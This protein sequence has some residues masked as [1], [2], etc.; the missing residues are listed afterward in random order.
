LSEQAEGALKK[1]HF[2]GSE[3]YAKLY[4]E[5]FKLS[6]TIDPTVSGQEIR[7]SVGVAT[8]D[9]HRNRLLLV[10]LSC[11][12][13]L[14]QFEGKLPYGS[15]IMCVIDKSRPCD[16]H[17]A[18]AGE[19]PF[20]FLVAST[21]LDEEHNIIKGIIENN[22][23]ILDPYGKPL[24]LRFEFAPDIARENQQLLCPMILGFIRRASLVV[25]ILTHDKY[26]TILSKEQGKITEGRPNEN[27]WFEYGLASALCD[28]VV[29]FIKE[30]TYVPSDLK[31]VNVPRYTDPQEL[32]EKM[33]QLFTSP[34]RLAS[35]FRWSN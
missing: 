1:G 25:I 3:E 5:L 26:L 27:V 18:V 4:N 22:L 30:N 12:Q 19:T 15:E 7:L 29:A 32:K 9:D 24:Q 14:A 13:L 2:F 35:R 20:A 6:Q 28:C 21:S 17:K 31:G 34:S 8:E 11:Q 10:R 16:C 23:K 33:R